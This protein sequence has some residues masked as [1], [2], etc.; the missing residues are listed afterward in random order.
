MVPEKRWEASCVNTVAS[1]VK[2]SKMKDRGHLSLM[3]VAY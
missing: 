2:T 3:G 1:S